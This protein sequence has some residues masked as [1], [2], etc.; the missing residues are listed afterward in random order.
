MREGVESSVSLLVP[1]ARD[2]QLNRVRNE[3]TVRPS[4]FLNPLLLKVLKLIFLHVQP[5]F[6]STANR[7]VN[8]VKGDGEGTAG[9]RFPD[10]LFVVIVLRDDLYT[11]GDD[12]SRIETDTELTNH[13]NIGT[14]TKRLHETLCAGFRDGSK[15]VDEAGFGHTNT[16]IPDGKDFV[17]LVGG[18]ADVEVLLGAGDGRVSE[19][20]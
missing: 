12:V 16:G 4:N 19:G 8:G 6:A 2:G 14:G 5:N 15:V 11:L 10:V 9:S 20:A 13:G 3:L 17:L 7:R 18:D 1:L